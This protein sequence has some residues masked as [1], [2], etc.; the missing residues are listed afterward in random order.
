MRVIDIDS[1]YFEPPDWLSQVDPALAAEIPPHDPIERVVRF[2]VGDLLDAV[3]RDQLPENLLE[4]LVF[5]SDVPHP[6]GR[7]G[8]VSIC[9]AQL[10]D[11]SVERRERFFGG[12][13]ARLLGM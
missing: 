12:E 3:P 10:A 6:E 13:I 4:L 9:E 8:A 1:H 11:V 7:D 5:S 2:V